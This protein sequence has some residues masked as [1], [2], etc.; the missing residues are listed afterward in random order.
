ME[1]PLTFVSYGLLGLA[2]LGQLR[3]RDYAIGLGIA[4]A[5]FAVFGTVLG[6]WPSP[7]AL[8]SSEMQASDFWLLAAESAVLGLF[9]TLRQ[10]LAGA[11]LATVGFLLTLFGIVCPVCNSVFDAVFGHG[12]LSA[13]FG[14]VCFYAGLVGIILSV[15]ALLWR[16]AGAAFERLLKDDALA[17]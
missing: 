6:A 14:N 5:I 4:I 9:F 12:F 13:R 2:N 1:T 15:L 11:P 16:S 3:R 17:I 10:R 7:F 8:R